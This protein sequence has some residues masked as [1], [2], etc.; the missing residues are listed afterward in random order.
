[1][2]GAPRPQAPDACYAAF[3]RHMETCQTCTADTSV[4]CPYGE[5][6]LEAWQDSERFYAREQ[7]IIDAVAPMDMSTVSDDA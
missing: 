2:T 3:T 7:R 1:M 5:H 4:V 6:L